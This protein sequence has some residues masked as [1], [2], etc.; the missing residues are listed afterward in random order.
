MQSSKRHLNG[1]L[2]FT[3]VMSYDDGM[4]DLT[5]HIPD[6][7][8][9]ELEAISRARHQ[10]VEDLVRDSLRRYV[11]VEQFRTL[12]AKTVPVAAAHGFH[13]DEDIF[14]STS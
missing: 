9:R 2:P 4:T 1:Y 5:V 7:L 12:R 8:R 10:P 3:A 13:E 14:R 11:A 6:Q